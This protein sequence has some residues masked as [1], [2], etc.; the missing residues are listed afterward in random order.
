MRKLT[1][2]LI[3]TGLVAFVACNNAK[4]KE[5]EQ[6]LK[7]SLYQDSVM[8]VQQAE[9]LKQDSIIA[10]EKAVRIKDSLKQDSIMKA[11]AATKG[12]GKKK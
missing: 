4:Q 7:D 3:A 10:A 8:K 6:K 9:Q 12:K 1:Y 11:E 2:L 5:A